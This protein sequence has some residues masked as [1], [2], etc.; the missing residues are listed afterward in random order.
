MQL[1]NENDNVTEGGGGGGGGGGSLN[2][3]KPLVDKS[4]IVNKSNSAG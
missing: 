3:S 4:K 2:Q 1:K